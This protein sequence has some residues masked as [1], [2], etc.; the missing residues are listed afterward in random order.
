KKPEGNAAA[1]GVKKTGDWTMWGGDLTR[2]MVNAS[3]GLDFTFKPAE[4]AGDGQNILWTASLGS[5]TYGNPVVAGGKVFVGTNNGGEYREKHKGDRGC[6]LCFNEA[7]GKFLWQ[8]T[9]EKLS[10]GRVN[11]WPEQ[12]ICSTP[13]I[14]DGLMYVV[15]NRCEL[16]CVDVEGFHD[17][18]NDG[19]FKDETDTEELDADIIWSLDMLDALGVF[20]H[21]LATSSPVIYGDLILIVTSNGVDEAHLEVPSPRAPSFIAVN[22]KTAEVVWEDGSPSLD[23]KAPE[24]FNNILHGQWGSPAVAEINGKAQVFMPGGD[25]I[26]YSFDVASG[27]LVWWFDLN[28]KD[29]EWELGGRGSRNNIISTPVFFD[30]SVILA[31]GQDP[32]HGEGVGHLYRIDATKTG[33]VSP[34]LKEGDSYSANPNSAQIWHVGGVDADGSITG[35]KNGLLFRRTISTAAISD[36]LVYAADLSGFLHC[37]DFKTGEKKWVYDTFAAVWGSPMV[38]DGHVLMG[39]EDGEMV[40]LKAGPELKE[41][42]TKTFN[43]SI[44]ST[45]TIANGTMFVSDRSRLYAIKVQ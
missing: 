15:T 24:P 31:V 39:D 35:E 21:N 37:I 20:P 3:T 17:G 11:D 29:S 2:N 30:N 36:G 19:P 34:Q 8:L 41:L 32:E 14:E 5:Q 4:E 9:R 6:V 45:P 7:D 13:V 43:S 23:S 22:K 1:A 33:D 44:Y 27:E 28:P 26:L 25:G 18:E 10:Q 40:I 16:M 12:G 42:E 38:V